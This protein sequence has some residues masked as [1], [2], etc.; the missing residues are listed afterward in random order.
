M[1]TIDSMSRITALV[2]AAV[3]TACVSPGSIAPNTSADE[4]LQKLGK[5]S[6]VRR[7]AN[8]GEAWDYVHGPAGYTTWRYTIDN[9][10]LVRNVDQLLTD[11]RF[12]KITIG[13]SREAD[14]IEQLGQP[15][16]KQRVGNGIAWEWRV[17]L[18]HTPGIYF[19]TFGPDGVVSNQGTITDIVAPSEF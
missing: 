15:R 1:K 6:E 9:K 18:T 2:L 4:L 10:R 19:V 5:P 11:E 8:G 14:V 16:M 7:T 3:L 12:H 17:I 13:L